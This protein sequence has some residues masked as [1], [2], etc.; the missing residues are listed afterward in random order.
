MVPV[1]PVDVSG[2]SRLRARAVDFEVIDLGW[3]GSG[4]IQRWCR[5]SDLRLTGVAFLGLVGGCT[6]PPAT[7]LQ[8]AAPQAGLPY[9]APKAAHPDQAPV[10]RCPT[11]SRQAAED[12]DDSESEQ[13]GEWSVRVEPLPNTPDL[14]AG[15]AT[16]FRPEG[17]GDLR[18]VVVF[19]RVGLGIDMFEHEAWRQAAVA[20]HYALIEADLIPIDGAVAAYGYPDQ[21]AEMLDSLLDSLAVESGISRV[22]TLPKVV[23]GHSAGAFLMTQIGAHRTGQTVGFIAF[24]GSVQDDDLSPGPTRERLLDPCFLQVPGMIFIG[25][26]DPDGIRDLSVELLHAGR[27]QGARWAL[28]F[29]PDAGHWDVESSLPLATAFVEQ[30]FDAARSR[31]AGLAR[32]DEGWIGELQHLRVYGINGWGI[33]IVEAVSVSED[34][35]GLPHYDS[36]SWFLSQDLAEQWEGYQREAID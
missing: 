21:A 19:S 17:A 1:P 24:H 7:V 8:R 16:L 13:T 6:E 10:E 35:T 15:S 23:W 14:L 30:A 2:R 5:R 34:P 33:E 29:D 4:Q 25:E 11:P 18:G 20:G 32:D 12:T 28:A 9:H 31:P 3:S 27:D 22:A 36:E 26:R